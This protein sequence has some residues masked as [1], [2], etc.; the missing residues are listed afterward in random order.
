MLPRGKIWIGYEDGSR[1]RGTETR[2]DLN[3]EGDLCYG[4]FIR[5]RPEFRGMGL[6]EMLYVIT[7]NIARELGCKRMIR[8]ASGQTPRG[9]SRRNYLVIKLDYKL[10]EYSSSDVEKP[11]S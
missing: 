3:I 6:G 7:E 4:V 2:F 10:V 1:E 9:E 5:L 11:L 8:A